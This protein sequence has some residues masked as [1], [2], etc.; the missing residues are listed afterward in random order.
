MKHLHEEQVVEWVSG[1]RKDESAQHLRECAQCLAEVRQLAGAFEGFKTDIRETAAQDQVAFTGAQIRALA[2]T[3][4]E[5]A[6]SFWKILPVPALAAVVL[7]AVMVSRP[8]PVKPPPP[9][10]ND[11]ADEALLLAVNS[12]VYHTA[13]AA[14]RPVASLNKER[15]QILTTALQKK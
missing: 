4:R 10:S 2:A 8:E 9:L 12:D 5:P 7:L 3:Q 11:A 14:L 6:K 15:N 1:E 13:P